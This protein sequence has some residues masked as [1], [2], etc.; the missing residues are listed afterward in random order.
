MH[1]RRSCTNRCPGC[2]AAEQTRKEKRRP[3]GTPACF[4]RSQPASSRPPVSRPAASGDASAASTSALSKSSGRPCCSRNAVM[5]SHARKNSSSDNWSS[6]R[7]VIDTLARRARSYATA[8][9]AHPTVL[10][11]A[12]AYPCRPSLERHS[13]RP[14]TALPVGPR[15]F[16]PQPLLLLSAP[17]FSC[18]AYPSCAHRPRR[19]PG[20]EPLMA[21]SGYSRYL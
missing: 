14:Q 11:S 7:V 16:Q 4:G 15:P 9:L 13:H 20:L 1:R 17:P 6:E 12:A 10:R 2:C 19:S 3:L 18:S 21:T 8:V 5:L